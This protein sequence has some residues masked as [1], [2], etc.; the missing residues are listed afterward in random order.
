MN[1]FSKIMCDT[2]LWGMAEKLQG[3]ATIQKDWKNGP[4]EVQQRQTQ[5]PILGA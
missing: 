4:P 1:I 3:T 5:C 2:K